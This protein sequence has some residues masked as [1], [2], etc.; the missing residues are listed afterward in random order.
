MIFISLGT[1]KFQ[2]NRLLKY[3]DEKI[4]CQEISEEVFAQ[5]GYSTYIPQSYEYKDF[6]D[7][8]EFESIIEKSNLL[9]THAGVGTIIAAMKYEK[10]IIVVP[11]L[12]KFEEHVD[13]HQLQIAEAFSR[14]NLIISNGEKIED[15]IDNINKAPQFKFEKYISSN[16]KIQSIIDDYI[17]SN[18]NIGE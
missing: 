3:I 6:L 18:F 1:Q 2:F 7:K 13:D 8:N 9:I 12:S 17:K 5:I 15:L 14:K 11:R 10:P 4:K 16:I